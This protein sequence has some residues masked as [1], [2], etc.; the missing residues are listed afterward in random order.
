M[1][2]RPTAAAASESDGRALGAVNVPARN[3]GFWREPT[4]G[5]NP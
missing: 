2:S 5:V 3:A 4:L 1:S